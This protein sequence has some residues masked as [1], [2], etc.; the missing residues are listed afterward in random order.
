MRRV[1]REPAP[2]RAL[3]FVWNFAQHRKPR[4]HI[5]AALMVVRCTCQHCVG[6]VL[7]TFQTARMKVRRRFAEATHIS[8]NLVARQQNAIA[9]IGGIFHRL[10]RE[11]RTQLLEANR[12]FWRG[13]HAQPAFQPRQR[14]AVGRHNIVHRSCD[15]RDK[16]IRALPAAVAA[17]HREMRQQRD[18]GTANGGPRDIACRHIRQRE[19][20]QCR[21]CCFELR[22]ERAR[23]HI[24]PRPRL[25]NREVSRPAADLA[26]EPAQR[27]LARTRVQQR[28]DLV[29][30]VITTGAVDFPIVRQVLS[31]T[32]DLLHHQPRPPFR[33]QFPASV[34]A[35]CGNTRVGRRDHRRG[36]PARRQSTLLRITGTAWCASP[37]ILQHPRCA[38]P[39]TR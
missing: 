26:P 18:Q 1:H 21:D 35:A 5:L 13:V 24:A 25:L 8:A 12:W 32:Q 15:R 4:P 30:E 33:C 28:A 11:R 3:P 29:H 6:E 20:M 22:G 36:R 7:E 39:P 9:V 17:I 16:R 37:R 19:T 10:G 38:A 31:G 27:R 23:Q 2:Y 34:P 14:A